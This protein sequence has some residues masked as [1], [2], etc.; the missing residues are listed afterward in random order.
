MTVRVLFSRERS[1]TETLKPETEAETE[2][3]T[4]QAE[5]RPRPRPSEFETETRPRRTNS[6]ARPSRGTTAPR[7]G[8]EAKASRPRPHSCMTVIGS[9]LQNSQWREK[10]N[11]S[12]FRSAMKTNATNVLTTDTQNRHDGCSSALRH[13]HRKRQ[14]P[15]AEAGLTREIIE[16]IA[17]IDRHRY[18]G[19][20][21]QRSL[22]PKKHV[23]R[24][25][26]RRLFSESAAPSV[27]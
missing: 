20:P 17:T 11:V 22:I 9:S 7:D 2:A 4:I 1:E 16:I 13:P 5:A 24:L 26:L 12:Y 19:V 6:E 25:R 23:N 14:Y 10:P 21:A 15:V 3:L 27:A 8:F 18:V